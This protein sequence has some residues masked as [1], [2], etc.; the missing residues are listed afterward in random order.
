MPVK[1][2]DIK[3]AFDPNKPYTPIQKTDDAKPTFDQNKPYVSLKKKDNSE[4]IGTGSPKIVVPSDLDPLSTSKDNTPATQKAIPVNRIKSGINPFD[5]TSTYQ[6]QITMPDG[7]PLRLNKNKSDFGDPNY[8]DDLQKR[9]SEQKITPDDIHNIADA[10]GKSPATINAY[11]KGGKQ[12]AFAVENTEN[13][14]KDRDRIAQVIDKF[15]HTYKGNYNINEVLSSPEKSA[16]FLNSAKTQPVKNMK[17]L[18]LEEATKTALPFISQKDLNLLEDMVIRQTVTDDK[19]KGV[20]KDETIKKIA[21]RTNPKGYAQSVAA[22]IPTVSSPN[23]IIGLAGNAYDATFGTKD[24]D[25]LLNTVKGEAELRYNDAIQ[26]NAVDKISQ[27][28]LTG[29]QDLYEQGQAELKTVDDDAVYKYPSLVKQEI[30]RRVNETI[31]RESGQLIDSDTQ[32]YTEKILGASP[33]DRARVMK[34]LGYLDDPKTKDL[35]LSMIGHDDYFADASYLGSVGSSFLEPFK[36]LGMSVAD[37]TGFRNKRDILSDKKKDE[38]FPKELANTKADFTLPL[39]GEVRVRNVLNTTANLAGMAVIAAATEGAGS[40]LGLAAKASKSLAAYTSF[41]LPSYDGA[42][43]DSYN[44]LDNDGARSLYATIT[45]VTNAEGGRFLDL[46]KITRIPGVSEVY[47]KMAQGLSE[48][49]LTKKGVRELLDEA[50]NPYIEFALKYGKNVTKGAATMAYFNISNNIERLAFGDP[51]IKAEDVLPQAGH[52]FIDGVTGMSI[53]GAFGAVADMRNEKNTSYKGFIYNMAL[54]HDAT[55]DVFKQGLKDGTYTQPEYNQ[56]MQI[57]NTAKVA[58]SA[59]DATQVENNVTFDENQKSVYVANKTAAAVLKNKLENTPKENESQR[60]EL[61]GQIERLDQQNKDVLEGLK[62]TPTLEPLYDLFE[63]EKEY[64]KALEGVNT[65]DVDLSKVEAAK[66]RINQAIENHEKVKSPKNKDAKSENTEVKT[67]STQGENK[68]DLATTDSF[69]DTNKKKALDDKAN[70]IAVAIYPGI[71]DA[72]YNKR[73]RAKILN[74]PLE[75]VNDMIG[76][77]EKELIPKNESEKSPLLENSQKALINLK[78]LRDEYSEIQNQSIVDNNNKT[79]KINE[80]NT[81]TFYEN[82]NTE[83]TKGENKEPLANTLNRVEPQLSE[84]QVGLLQPVVDKVDKAELVN[85]KELNDAQNVLYEAL[86]KNAGASHLIEPLILKLQDYEHTTKTETGTVT[87]KEPIEGTFAAKTKQ[88]IKP[89][90]EQSAGSTATVTLPDGGVRKGKLNIKGGQYVLDMADAPQVIIGEKAI[91]DR[92]LKLPSEE[93]VAE[94]IKFDK[95][96]NVESVTFETRNGNLV[97]IEDPEKALD[98]AI[99]LQADAIGTIPDAAFDKAYT[100]IEKETQVEVPVKDI[101][102]QTKTEQDGKINEKNAPEKESSQKN[103]ESGEEGSNE[104][105]DVV[106][107]GV[108]TTTGEEAPLIKHSVKLNEETGKYE[109]LTPKGFVVAI[110]NNEKEANEAK[111]RIDEPFNKEKPDEQN[112]TN[113]PPTP[114]E[115][116]VVK[117]FEKAGNNFSAITKARTS[118]LEAAKSMFDRESPTKWTEVHQNAMSDLQARYPDKTIYEGAKEQVAEQARNYDNGVDYNPTSKD[119]AVMQYLKAETESRIKKLNID[120]ED[121]I[122]MAAASTQYDFLHDDL[123]NIAKASQKREAGTAFGIR[124]REVRLDYDS[125]AGLQ[126]RRIQLIK[127]KGGEP[128]SG[129]ENAWTAEQ[130]E[131]EKELLQRENDLKQQ[132]MQETFDKEIAKLTKEYEDKLKTAGKKDIP[133]KE[134]TLSQSGKD[135]ADK[136]RKLKSDKGT[137]NI[138]VTFGLKDLAV[139]AVAQLVE[140]GAKLVDA[141]AEVLKDAKYKGLSNNELTKH[142]I[143]GID[144]Q[145]N[146]AVSFDK[147]KDFAENNSVDTVTSEMVGKGLIT[148][149]VNSYLGEEKPE[150]ILKKA[151][152][153]LKGALPQLT[154]E[155]LREA[156]I[157]RGEFKQPTKKQLENEH[158]KDLATLTRIAKLETDISDLKNKGEVYLDKGQVTAAKAVDE[159]IIEKER[160]LKNELNKQ[161]KKFSATDKYAK[162]SYDSR[163]QS[164]NDRLS[165]LSDKI[166]D[167]LDKGNLT[168]AHKSALSVLKDALNKITI[169]LNPESKLDQSPVLE[170]GL[171]EVKKIKGRFELAANKL[172]N[173]SKL[174]EFKKDLQRIIDK[175]NSDKKETEQDI[176]LARAKDQLRTKNNETLRKIGAGEFEGK[177]I[178]TLTKS[179]KELVKLQIEKNH[180]DSEFHKRGQ[181]IRDAN[182]SNFK[183]FLEI[184]RAAYVA[185]L[186]YKFGTFAKVATAGLTRPTMEALTKLTGGKLFNLEFKDISVAAKRGGE[187]NSW[188]SIQ[189]SFEAQFA[190]RGEKKMAEIYNKANEKSEQSALAYDKKANEL[191]VI[192]KAGKEDSK[193]FKQGQ[194]ELQKLQ[195]KANVDLLDAANNILY[196]FIGGSSVKDA[197]QALLYRSNKIEQMFGF[198]DSEN[199]KGKN[200]KEMLQNKIDNLNYLIGFIGR[201]HSAAKTFSARASFA[202]GFVAR[203]EAAM[204]NGEDIR[205]KFLEI[206]EESYMD[207]DRGKYQQKNFVTDVMNSITNHLDNAFEDN[208]AWD[209]YAKATGAF[210]K[211]DLPITRVPVNI[212]HEAVAEY[213]F[214]LITSHIAA[215]NEYRKARKEVAINTDALPNSKE[216]K[217]A[218]KERMQGMD[219]KT[220]ATIARSYRKGVFGLGLYGTVAMLGIMEFGGFH[221][222]G[223]KKKK[224]SELGE[225]ELNAGD[226]MLGKGKAA[227]L[228]AK[229]IEH[230]PAFYP[231]LFGMN[232]ANV[233]KDKVEGGETSWEAAYDA[234]YAN[235]EAMQDAIPQT[236]IINPLGIMADAK[237]AAINQIAPIS[238]MDDVDEEGNMIKRKTMNV[239]DQINLMRGKRGEVLSEEN[240]KHVQRV[241]SDYKKAIKSLYQQNAPQTEIDETIKERDEAIKEIRKLNTEQYELLKENKK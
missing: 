79:K 169:K 173:I 8:I 111:D 225:G 133:K 10:S 131:K 156:Y 42:L 64:N 217:A 134:K 190:Q 198:M 12:A 58:K 158:K 202:A 235:L 87:E 44:F 115:K 172:D 47:S 112:I 192:K 63:A 104:K 137:T 181:K 83:E 162:S 182:K 3:P 151:A 46:G 129:E 187:S 25:D 147:I 56:K 91:T 149:Y 180:I 153:D 81:K 52:A 227:D 24:K 93:K 105:D 92:D 37:I 193:E 207:W 130:W 41:G 234:A 76:F 39:I 62:F 84:E 238:S 55:A 210:L 140:K 154:E 155:K 241:N 35:A 36:E 152:E 27:G 165:N 65:G 229:I 74:N 125:D 69:T 145:E 164:H 119:I 96:G 188:R 6:T 216:F 110:K 75:E 127:E 29:K 199:I 59:M 175:F 114:P 197:L 226:I 95:D 124:N 128:L 109:V 68:E 136:I 80:E 94:P 205:G 194:K 139:E 4:D 26:K 144:R 118:E 116:E 85:E 17:D 236:K 159:R 18:P 22:S 183:K 142:I 9:I 220:A 122:A 231:A 161:G 203:M 228:L 49:S 5:I 179:D 82:K 106:K 48:N 107:Q 71:G 113:A 186:I 101:L 78:K 232:A 141:I 167:K 239:S 195:N 70:E 99:Q 170:D 53:M 14:G 171:N 21:Q 218:L 89:A 33:V 86:D 51:S 43:K 191:L 7:S 138:D 230:T 23:D 20:S 209:K 160:E 38:M 208:P 126:A 196:Q 61:K 98:I 72:E 222:K 177:P 31:G 148:D 143:D 50:K 121:T 233:Y 163:A 45:A 57:L 168:D 201:S 16:E 117:E 100:T 224:E 146:R 67:E 211:L 174:G 34:Q 88:E 66:E 240:Y 90:L 32:N 13:N 157:K 30:A 185:T 237:K 73:G 2:A 40:E 123:M 189:K 97:S 132:G 213:T 135:L 214:G 150:D 221:H 28:I 15:N 206:A 108:D 102:S 200:A 54:N 11:V 219:A 204:A 212:L 178:V 1:S 176:K 184:T 19:T 60:N 215:A 120:T 77:Y 166:A 223:E 103:G